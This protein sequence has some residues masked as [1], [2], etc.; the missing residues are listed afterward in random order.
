MGMLQEAIHL[1]QSLYEVT[2]DRKRAI[3]LI[4]EANL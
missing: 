4:K 1:A 3:S 2:G